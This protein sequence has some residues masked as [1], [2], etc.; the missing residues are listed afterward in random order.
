MSLP[1]LCSIT[2]NSKNVI[3]CITFSMYKLFQQ[4]NK[5]HHFCVW[6]CYRAIY[7]RLLR[8]WT[9]GTFDQTIEKLKDFFHWHFLA[10]SLF[11]QQ[12]MKVKQRAATLTAPFMPLNVIILNCPSVQTK[13]TFLGKKELFT[14]IFYSCSTEKQTLF[15]NK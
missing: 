11:R 10:S 6:V 8:C 1:V 9:R 13:C 15:K 14:I 5:W 3:F 7:G 12:L 4:V 2:C